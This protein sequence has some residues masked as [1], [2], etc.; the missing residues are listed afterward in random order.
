MWRHRVGTVSA[1]RPTK[2]VASV[3]P[4]HD[5]RAPRRPQP[6]GMLSGKQLDASAT[7][8]DERMRFVLAGAMGRE[9][10]SPPGRAGAKAGARDQR[11]RAR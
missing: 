2:E 5:G 7:G 4:V 6:F 3:R 10:A 8:G 9:G 1:P 11:G